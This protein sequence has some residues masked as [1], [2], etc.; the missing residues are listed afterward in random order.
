M[1]G[2]LIAPQG[3]RVT[4]RDDPVHNPGNHTLKRITEISVIGDSS[5]VMVAPGLIRSQGLKVAMQYPR[6]HVISLNFSG[7]RR[8]QPPAGM[9]P[10]TANDAIGDEAADLF[11]MPRPT[12]A[13]FALAG[14]DILPP[15]I[16][17]PPEEDG[18]YFEMVVRFRPNNPAKF[19]HVMSIIATLG[20]DA[21]AD[22]FA[23]G[24]GVLNV[25]QAGGNVNYESQVIATPAARPSAP[26]SPASATR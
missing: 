13:G 18:L 7:C 6:A 4:L 12:W 11:E 21:F 1:S 22:H 2:G 15:T 24:V 19:H 3:L 20:R 16:N 10:A 5:V 25:G 8:G 26:P 23:F 17:Y 14:A 9:R